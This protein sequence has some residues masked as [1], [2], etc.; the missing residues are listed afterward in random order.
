MVSAFG[1]DPG[2]TIRRPRGASG[3]AR[4][5][6]PHPALC[7]PEGYA[8]IS[9]TGRKDP[10]KDA[11]GRQVFISSCAYPAQP[12]ENVDPRRDVMVIE[13][14]EFTLKDGRKALIRS[15]REEDVPAMLDYLRP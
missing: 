14:I 8:I 13:D 12:K 7:L 4:R 1:T 6:T 11:H 2:L 9:E 10:K 5:I 3:P 15:P